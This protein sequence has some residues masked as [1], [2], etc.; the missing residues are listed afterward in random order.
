MCLS[1]ITERIGSP[2]KLIVGGWKEFSVMN[3]KP[4]FMNT[5]LNHNYEVPLDKWI[6]AESVTI[7]MDRKQSYNSG[8]HIY[9]DEVENKKKKL[10][11]LRRVFYRGVETI[12]TQDGVPVVIAREMYVPSDPDAWPPER[13]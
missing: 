9:S 7:D 2:T 10:A 8:F 3:G 4:R 12:G 13:S 5:S 1:T 11:N 6:T